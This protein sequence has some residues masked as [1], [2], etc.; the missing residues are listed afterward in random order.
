MKTACYFNNTHQFTG[1]MPAGHL[2]VMMQA[3]F[4]TEMRFAPI[5]HPLEPS[6]QLLE[7]PLHAHLNDH[8]AGSP[9]AER[10]P[11]GSDV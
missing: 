4:Q 9:A 3:T 6:F 7:H 8:L 5:P 10:S 1:L 11:D 2:A